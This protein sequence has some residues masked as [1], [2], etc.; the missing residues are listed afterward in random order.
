MTQAVL[1]LLSISNVVLSAGLQFIPLLFFGAGADV[2]TFVA[3]L[4]VPGVITSVSAVVVTY[5][6]VPQFANMDDKTQRGLLWRAM[7]SVTL[8]L[9]LPSAI[10]IASAH[11]WV[12]WS[13]PGFAPAQVA[14]TV[15]LARV[16]IIGSLVGVYALVVSARLQANGRFVANASVAAISA[17][18]AIA[19]AAML[20]GPFGIVVAAWSL[21]LRAALQTGLTWA[22]DPPTFA[23]LDR[24]AGVAR[25]A[26]PL[27]V[28]SAVSKLEPL[29]DRALLTSS[30]PGVLTLFY[31]AQQI[32]GALSQVANGS[33][34]AHVL[35]RLSRQSRTEEPAK[36]WKTARREV[37]RSAV[38]GL[39][40]LAGSVL[41]VASARHLPGAHAYVDRIDAATLLTLMV[42][43][44][45]V[46]IFGL[47]GTVLSSCYYARGDTVT[48]SIVAVAGFAGAIVLKILGFRLFGAVGLAL[49]NSLYFCATSAAMF[50]LL[51]R[52]AATDPSSA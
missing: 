48:P 46:L 43:L 27:L 29:V 47:V 42:A 25:R 15:E 7:F 41:V 50:L 34:L 26:A 20:I 45:G 32:F 37:A 51:R 14:A 23:H 52:R 12:P 1:F 3:A 4:T 19:F 38:G 28:G 30:P 10:L 39:V 9:A 5:T 11:L 16:S 21:V 31:F 36:V 8:F 44:S 40:F 49:A 6:L 2:D 22:I 35:M 24:Q 13:V 33:F 18:V 17:A